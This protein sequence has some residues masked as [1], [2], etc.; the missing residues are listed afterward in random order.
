MLID[1][2][3]VYQPSNAHNI[4]CDPPEFPTATYI[5]T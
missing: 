5:E 3:R 1:Y 4:G 2:V